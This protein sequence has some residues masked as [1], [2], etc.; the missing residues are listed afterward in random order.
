M[1]ISA[2]GRKARDYYKRRNIPLHKSWTGI[3]GRIAYANVQEIAAEII[4]NYTNET[5]DE[6]ILVYNEFKSVVAQK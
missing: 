2:V 1:N 3:S 5:V 4:E 6:V